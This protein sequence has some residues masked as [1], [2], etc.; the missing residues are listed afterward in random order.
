MSCASWLTVL[1]L[2]LLA[3]ACKSDPPAE[4]AKRPAWLRDAK[5]ETLG[6]SEAFAKNSEPTWSSGDSTKFRSSS[7]VT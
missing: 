5:I 4:R 1:G 3:G 6:S 2:C 7:K